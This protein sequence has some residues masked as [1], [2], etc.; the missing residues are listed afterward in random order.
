VGATADELIAAVAG[1]QDGVV[2]R[3]QVLGDVV[4]VEQLRHRRRRK[5]LKPI[6][7][8]VHLRAGLDLTAK[9]GAVAAR[10]ACGAAAV[11]S[12]ETAAFVWERRPT[13]PSRTDITTAAGQPRS[14]P[15]YVVHRVPVLDAR[16]V[17]MLDGNPVTSPARTLLDR[18]GGQT[19]AQIEREYDELR[20]ARLLQPHDVLAA[21]DRAPHRRNER[22]LVEL[23]LDPVDLREEASGGSATSCSPVR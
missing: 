23:E 4:N 18:A 5:Q 21:L 8:G 14:T 11:W 12:H 6:H 7:D 20:I 10:L 2:A 13:L 15:S 19:A 1:A 17:R 16:D 22:A 9:R 3:W